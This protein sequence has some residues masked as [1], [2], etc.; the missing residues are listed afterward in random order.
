M[1]II[2]AGILLFHRKFAGLFRNVVSAQTD[3]ADTS[4]CPGHGSRD[5]DQEEAA[6]V[7]CQQT[8][9]ASADDLHDGGCQCAGPE[10]HALDR[11]TEDHQTAVEDEQ[12]R[13]DT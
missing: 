1:E 4:Q 8:R 12:G 5:A 2:N 11:V 13:D 3:T 9:G 10:A 6:V 7:N